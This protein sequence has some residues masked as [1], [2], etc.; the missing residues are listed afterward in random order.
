MDRFYNM[1]SL[2]KFLTF[3]FG[4]IFQY[5]KDSPP[6]IVKKS[7]QVANADLHGHTPG[8]CRGV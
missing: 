6:H 2:K 5:G 3:Y 4:L 1:I 8:P 7:K